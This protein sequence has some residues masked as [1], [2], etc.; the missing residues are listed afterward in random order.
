M[1]EV[2]R[3]HSLAQSERRRASP[4]K[5][6]VVVSPPAVVADTHRGIGEEGGLPRGGA[7]EQLFG[8]QLVGPQTLHLDGY[9]SQVC[10]VDCVLP[11]SFHEESRSGLEDRWGDMRETE[12]LTASNRMNAIA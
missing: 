4:G 8:L 3:N 7:N 6:W 2:N 9:F 1:V 10:C 5:M 12:S 11:R